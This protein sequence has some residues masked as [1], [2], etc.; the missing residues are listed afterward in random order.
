[1]DTTPLQIREKWLRLTIT[2]S[3]TLI[4]PYRPSREL[5]NL[6]KLKAFL[7]NEVMPAW[8]GVVGWYGLHSDTTKCLF[9]SLAIFDLLY[10]RQI[11]GECLQGSAL[12]F[13]WS[14]LR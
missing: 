10:A 14:S 9:H 6:R 4:D 11:C 7:S 13:S 1:M 3:N 8:P 12:A 2:M 5:R